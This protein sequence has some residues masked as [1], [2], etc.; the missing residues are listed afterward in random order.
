MST[1][2]TILFADDNP[3]IREICRRELEDE[4]YSVPVARNGDEAVRL[5]DKLEPDLVVLDIC[6]PGISGLQAL[7]RIRKRNPSLPVIL[8]TSFDD[9]CI[10]DPRARLA[11]ACVEK[12][13]DLSTLKKTIGAALRSRRE[14]RPYRV[15]LP[16]APRAPD[17]VS[18]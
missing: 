6:M 4:G 3:N 8:F 9:A 1:M 18:R 11:T 13:E 12:S 5:T 7:A 17:I 16:S 10:D 15:G 2:T 14:N